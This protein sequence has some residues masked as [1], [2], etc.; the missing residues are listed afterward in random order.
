MWLGLT[1]SMFS[2]PEWEKS[3][4]SPSESP[5]GPTVGNPACERYL[6]AKHEAKVIPC[7]SWNVERRRFALVEGKQNKKM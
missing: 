5:L 2:S 6:G 3:R 1:C 7:I 4:S